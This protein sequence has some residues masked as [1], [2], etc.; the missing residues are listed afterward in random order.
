MET[1]DGMRRQWLPVAPWI[2]EG[3]HHMTGQDMSHERAMLE[4]IQATLTRL[5]ELSKQ[6][7][8]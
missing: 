8:T 5:T 1:D 4:S 7:K 2:D 6:L 3:V